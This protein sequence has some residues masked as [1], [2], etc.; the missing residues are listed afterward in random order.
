MIKIYKKHKRLHKRLKSANKRQSSTANSE[1][2]STRRMI[3]TL[4]LSG[5]LWNGINEVVQEETASWSSWSRSLPNEPLPQRQQS[6]PLHLCTHRISLPQTSQLFGHHHGKRLSARNF[7]IFLVIN[8][9]S[10][11]IAVLWPLL[12]WKNKTR[13]CKH[14]CSKTKSIYLHDNP[15]LA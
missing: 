4:Q 3:D 2:V 6:A 1:A 12:M 15:H 10:Q 7:L 14:T 13:A 11:P 9:C 5:R 8:I